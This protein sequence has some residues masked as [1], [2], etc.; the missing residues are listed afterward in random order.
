MNWLKY[1]LLKSRNLWPITSKGTIMLVNA[2]I[3]LY[4]ADQK[5]WSKSLQNVPIFMQNIAYRL[6]FIRKQICH[7]YHLMARIIELTLGYFS[8]IVRRQ[9]N[10]L[11]KV[12][13]QGKIEETRR[14]EWPRNRWIDRVKS[15][16]RQPLPVLYSTATDP[17]RWH[18]LSRWSRA[19][20]HNGALPTTFNLVW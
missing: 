12:I 16:I 11:E 20:K 7:F 5:N 3:N 13:L 9:G 19:V 4:F 1:K 6:W 2:N 18:G 8:H 14:R 15:L 17:D 10:C